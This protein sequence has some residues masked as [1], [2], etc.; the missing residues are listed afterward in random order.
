[1]ILAAPM[2]FAGATRRLWRFWQPLAVEAQGWR[3]GGLWT[4]LWLM[5]V[6]AWAGVLAWYLLL[7]AFGVV[8]LLILISVRM[9]RRNGCKA[10]VAQLRHAELMAALHDRQ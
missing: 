9:V 3:K 8:P 6:L 4:A 5:L 2:S 10:E 1:M 7:A